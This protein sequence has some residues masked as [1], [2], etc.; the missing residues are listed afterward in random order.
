[1]PSVSMS[2][3][4]NSLPAHNT[5][6]PVDPLRTSSCLPRQ[7]ARPRT[8][9]LASPRSV[10]FRVSEISRR[11]RS[12]ATSLRRCSAILAIEERTIL[13]LLQ[14]NC[15]VI[16][17]RDASVNCLARNMAI[18]RGNA[19]TRVLQWSVISSSGT[20]KKSATAICICSMVIFMTGF[21]RA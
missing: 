6:R 3:D 5:Y 11:A 15:R 10:G 2:Y 17:A 1:M 8:G 16:S 14:L 19:I 7:F 9:A 12:T 20:L 18:G 4:L 21:A 13:W